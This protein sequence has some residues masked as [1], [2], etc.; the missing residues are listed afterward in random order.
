MLLYIEHENSPV[1]TIGK[2]YALDGHENM[3]DI[4]PQIASLNE[5]IL[6]ETV[7]L[8]N[9][10]KVCREKCIAVKNANAMIRDLSSL[11]YDRWDAIKY[12]IIPKEK[13]F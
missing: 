13:V 9:R 1:N 3:I 5:Y 12:Y 6:L 8:H 7:Y 2:Y 11:L 10:K 4:T